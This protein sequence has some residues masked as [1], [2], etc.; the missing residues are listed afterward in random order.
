MKVAWYKDWHH[1]GSGT[2]FA[3]VYYLQLVRY[4]VS[5]FVPCGD[6]L[7]VSCAWGVA[8]MVLSMHCVALVCS[9]V[10]VWLSVCDICCGT[11]VQWSL[12][13]QP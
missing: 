11:F 13:S 4:G 1:P 9:C 5:G 6:A 10:L 2:V 3:A 7:N 8:G 12:N